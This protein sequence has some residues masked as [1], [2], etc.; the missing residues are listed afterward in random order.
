MTP[1]SQIPTIEVGEADARRRAAGPAPALIVD[2]REMNEFT[3]VRVEGVALL[4]MSSFATRYTEIPKDR[5]IMVMCAAGSRS[6][7]A[8]AYLLRAGWTDVVNVA[9]GIDAWQRVGLPV[10]SGPIAAGEGDLPAA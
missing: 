3:A 7:A 2:V 5:P 9:G 4:P 6:A 8:T 1:Q 10:V